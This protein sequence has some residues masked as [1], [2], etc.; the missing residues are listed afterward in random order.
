MAK[1][2]EICRLAM[3]ASSVHQLH[4]GSP[5]NA[6]SARPYSCG[7]PRASHTATHR[8]VCLSKHGSMLVL[9]CA[10]RASCVMQSRSLM[11]MAWSALLVHY[12]VD[13]IQQM[14]TS[15]LLSPFSKGEAGHGCQ[16]AFNS[17]IIR[18]GDARISTQLSALIL[19]IVAESHECSPER[20]LITSWT[21]LCHRCST[22]A[23]AG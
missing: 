17:P 1:F 9:H 8:L 5:C 13:D 14:N 6:T 10:A 22:E 12:S 11:P 2:T 23:F 18:D 21:A 3:Q 19:S 4:A 15:C 20:N 16:S 7:L